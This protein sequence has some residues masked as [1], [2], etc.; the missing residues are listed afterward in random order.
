MIN[1]PWVAFFLVLVFFCLICTPVFAVSSTVPLPSIDLKVQQSD[2]PEEVV[3]SVQL[4][5]LITL[6]SLAPAF[7]IMMTGFIRIVIVLSFVR[8]SLGT[9][10]IPPNQVIIG[11]ALILTFFVMYPVYQQVDAQA[12]QPY[13]DGEISRETALELGSAPVKDFMLKQTREKD[14][15][16]FVKIAGIEKPQNSRDIPMRVV[17]PG[18]IISELKTAFQMGFI[19]YVPFLVIDMVVASILMSMGMFMLPPVMIALPFK[20]LLFIMVDG[21]FLVV[22]SLMESF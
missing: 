14:L 9:Q 20:I 22:K 5:V 8:T 4:L 10:Q 15:A 12:V 18:F 6:L 7:L 21:W 16:L 2:R 1:K 13:L 19:L 3:E 11:L 17:I